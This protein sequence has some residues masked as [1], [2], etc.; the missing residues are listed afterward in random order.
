MKEYSCCFTGHRIIAFDD[1]EK[2]EK[3]MRQVMEA[4]IEGGVTR[5]ICGGALGFDTLAALSVLKL[6]ETFPHI[7]LSLA[8]PCRDQAARWTEKQRKLYEDILM[9][10]DHTDYM[11]DHYVQGCMQM[12]NRFMVDNADICIA[13]YTGRPGGTRQTVNYA[14]EKSVRLI[15][16]PTKE[17]NPWEA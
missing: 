10:A 12:R 5:F 4:L 8:L 2:I 17:E 15:F 3:D 11:F 7:T 16:V 13:Y 14:K 1:R 9:K 6:K